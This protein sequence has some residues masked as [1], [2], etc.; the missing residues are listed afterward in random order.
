MNSKL[1]SGVVEHNKYSDDNSYKIKKNKEAILNRD[2]VSHF[3]LSM[4]NVNNQNDVEKAVEK[5]FNV[6][7]DTFFSKM[8]GRNRVVS[9]YLHNTDGLI[10]VKNNSLISKDFSILIET[11][12]DEKFSGGGGS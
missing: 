3:K 1:I 12:K 9:T 11:K 2:D 4:R 5:T 7:L 6:L 8:Y 10:F